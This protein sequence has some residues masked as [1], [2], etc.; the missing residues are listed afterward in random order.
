MIINKISKWAGIVMMLCVCVAVTTSC[1]KTKSYAE[2]RDEE[3]K[4]VEKF[5]KTQTVINKI[6]ADSVFLIGEDAPYYKLDD[7]GLVY[8]QVLS[9]SET[10]KKAK[11]NEAIFFRYSRINILTWAADGEQVPS[12]ND[13]DLGKAYYFNFQNTVLNSTT[14][15][16]TGIQ[17]PLYYINVPCKVNLLIKSKAGSTNDLTSVIPYLYTI[18]YNPS[19]I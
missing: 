9:V 19:S 14:Q 17:Q 4:A 7:D 10:G 5:L 13:N 12:G 8:M 16:G 2:L 6:P 15:Y 3:D 1:E 11:Y 18:R